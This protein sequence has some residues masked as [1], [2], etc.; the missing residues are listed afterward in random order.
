MTNSI[1][2]QLKTKCLKRVRVAGDG[3]C[4]FRALVYM[5][6]HHHNTISRKGQTI[7]HKNL[8]NLAIRLIKKQKSHYK[9]FVWDQ[10]FPDYLD[11]MSHGAY[12]DNLTLQALADYFDMCI[13]VLR[14]KR[15]RNIINND[16]KHQITL[17]YSGDDGDDAHYDATRPVKNCVTTRTSAVTSRQSHS[18]SHS[19]T[20]ARKT[21]RKSHSKTRARK[22]HSKTRARK[23][24]RKSHSK[25]RARK[26]HSKT[27]AR[28]S[29][30]TRKTRKSRKSRKSRKTHR[31]TRKTHRKPRKTRKTHRKPR[32]THRK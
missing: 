14:H 15:K 12:G 28:K 16:G 18:K 10:C 25:T 23:T 5:I 13:I 1:S 26:T 7:D 27:R 8:R 11:D 31:K 29:R 9:H 6:D 4:Q 30:K 2:S 24:H 20:R 17:I 3:N 22:T 32:K 19:K 21:H